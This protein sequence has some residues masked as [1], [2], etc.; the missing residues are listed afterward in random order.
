MNLFS[1]RIITRNR[2]LNY[3]EPIIQ[4]VRSEGRRLSRHCL[5]IDRKKIGL[6]EVPRYDPQCNDALYNDKHQKHLQK[7]VFNIFI[8]SYVIFKF[9]TFYLD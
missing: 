6:S 1:S 8:L 7:E 4:L 5:L 2:H 9:V 3:P